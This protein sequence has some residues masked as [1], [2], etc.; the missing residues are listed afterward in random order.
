MGPGE[1]EYF[2]K[3]A[4]SIISWG[5]VGIRENEVSYVEFIKSYMYNVN[6]DPLEFFV[7]IPEKKH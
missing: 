5:V 4:R 2:A 7:P 3:F 1:R 6:F